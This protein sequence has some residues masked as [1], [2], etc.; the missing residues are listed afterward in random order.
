[1][2]DDDF[3]D[4][5]VED[6]VY[7]VRIPKNDWIFLFRL[8][9]INFFN[10]PFSFLKWKKFC[11]FSHFLN[12]CNIEQRKLRWKRNVMIYEIKKN[13]TRSH[14]I[15]NCMNSREMRKILYHH[16][17]YIFTL[18]IQHQQQITFNFLFFSS[19]NDRIIV[20][21]WK[22]II[23]QKMKWTSANSSDRKSVFYTSEDASNVISTAKVSRM[24][25]MTQHQR[26]KRRKVK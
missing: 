13:S 17:N 9:T 18:T 11:H 6:V 22:I 5:D 21:I 26:V 8:T 16:Q 14:S 19:N 7:V 24:M 12:P 10:F 15:P 2:Q 20:C 23:Y 3:D 4:F 25:M 1:M